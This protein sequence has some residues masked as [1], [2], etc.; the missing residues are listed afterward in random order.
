MR[1]R[2]KLLDN[3]KDIAC[4]M[5]NDEMVAGDVSDGRKGNFVS[6]VHLCAGDNSVKMSIKNCFCCQQ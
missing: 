6:N 5:S 2:I 3:G 1:A 4:R